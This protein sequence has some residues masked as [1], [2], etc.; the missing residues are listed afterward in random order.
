MRNEKIKLTK[1]AVEKLPYAQ[2]DSTGKVKQYIVW[3][4][5]LVGFGVIV[6]ET[7]KSYCY[8]Y[9]DKNNKTVRKNIGRVE[10]IPVDTAR[11]MAM[12]KLSNVAMGK[13]VDTPAVL[14]LTAAFERMMARTD[15]TLSSITREGYQFNY[16]KYLAPLWANRKLA[17]IT[18]QECSKLHSEI[19][20]KYSANMVMRVFRLVWSYNQKD[21]EELEVCPTIGVRWNK[22]EPREAAIDPKDLPR[23]YAA[24]DKRPE[25]TRDIFLFTL[26]SG[27]RKNDVLSM[28]WKNVDLVGRSLLIPK[29][30]SQKAFKIPLSDYLVEIL[31]RRP[32][33]SNFVFPGWGGSG[34]LRDPGADEVA[35]RFTMHGLR[36]TYITMANRA[37]I[38]IYEQKLLTNHAIPRTDAH[39]GYVGLELDD[40][41]EAQQK[42]TDVLIGALFLSRNNE[43]I[44]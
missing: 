5:Q 7:T 22:E 1:Q 13:P 4:T 40:L 20:G 3:D 15:K 43:I 2:R 14:T 33:V 16:D 38:G 19:K 28:E 31:N 18:R 24:I 32:K 35:F 12:E 39:S 34:H 21:F 41:R 11:K 29:P 37:K 6:S 9:N 8:R 42:I 44:K 23:W 10:L 36:H 17:S 26:F 27:L 30:K 25:Q